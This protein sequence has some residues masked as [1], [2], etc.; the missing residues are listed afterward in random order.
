[1]LALNK[2]ATTWKVVVEAAEQFF[3]QRI[4]ELEKVCIN[5]LIEAFISASIS[6][7]LTRR[8]YLG[9]EAL[10]SMQTYENENGDPL[11]RA[12]IVILKSKWDAKFISYLCSFSSYHPPFYWR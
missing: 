5:R 9:S 6:S 7:Q 3:N 8:S 11:R 10:P 12:D 4:E 1:M 2:V